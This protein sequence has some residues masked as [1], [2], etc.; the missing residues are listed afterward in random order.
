MSRQIIKQ[1][2]GLYCVFSTIS[3]DIIYYNQSPQDLIEKEIKEQTELITKD[4]TETV[5][6]L[7]RG[8][9]PGFQFT[10]T[11]FDMCERIK[12]YH[13]K[14]RRNKVQQLIEGKRD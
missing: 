12:E 7:E 8:E 6:R 9:K 3:D 13:G 4:I 11:Y 2:N 1:P 10:M 5:E 14:T